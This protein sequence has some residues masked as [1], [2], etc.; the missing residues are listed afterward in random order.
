ML[1]AL[2]LT[3]GLGT[4]LD[5]ITR[6]LAKPAVPL[7]DRTL[8]EHVLAWLHR[9]GVRDLVLNLHHRP[10]TITS[11]VGDGAHLGMSVRYSWEQP[12]LGSAGGPRR[13]APLLATDTFLIVN[14]DT[15][16]DLD[17]ETLLDVHRQSKA[18]VTLAVVPNTEPD[19]YNGLTVSGDGV[20]KGVVPRGQA[21][22]SWHFVG[23]QVV[24]S[25]VFAVLEDGVP[26][27]TVSGL[28]R[29][30]IAREPGRV[31]AWRSTAT[32]L[33]VGTPRDYLTTA[34]RYG[35][36]ANAGPVHSTQSVVW[37]NVVCG[38]DVVFDDCIVAGPLRVPGGF[39]ARSSVVVPAGV[40]RPGDAADVRGNVAV[41]PMK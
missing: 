33:D 25:K 3:A 22:G 34:L 40:V 20:I 23:V 21:E 24:A 39:R 18:D 4:R 5:P 7:G 36:A 8:I 13:A 31:R 28:Y 37:P 41:F 9:Q 26:A 35:G 2:V 12:V 1:P 19:R 14:G 38:A 16:C 10:S 29:D 17:L 15:L 32:F 27:E 30:L 6:L 11:V